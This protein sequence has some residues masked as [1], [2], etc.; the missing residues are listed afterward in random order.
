[1]YERESFT[2]N[3]ESTELMTNFFKKIYEQKRQVINAAEREA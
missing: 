3:Y 2:A 1:M